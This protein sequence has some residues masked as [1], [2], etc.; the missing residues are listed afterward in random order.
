MR[1]EI[2]YIAVDGT[3]FSTEEKCLE[4]ENTLPILN[5]D[6]IAY[7]SNEGK[8]IAEPDEYVLFSSN[9]FM[10]KNLEGLSAY[11]KFCTHHGLAVP[12]VPMYANFD[13]GSLHFL[14][15]G[16]TWMCFEDEIMRL[17]TAL[18]NSYSNEEAPKETYH[19]LLGDVEQFI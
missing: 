10:V 16:G 11:I 14:F 17:Q 6:C 1:K 5:P 3:I 7:F 9:R 19:D 18:A 15:S 2:T 8:R 4:Y 12:D 13:Y